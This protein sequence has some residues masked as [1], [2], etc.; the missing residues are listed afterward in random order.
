MHVTM[1]TGKSW[2]DVGVIDERIVAMGALKRLTDGCAEIRRMR[3]HPRMQR[4]AWARR[5]CGHL[6]A[7]PGATVV[8]C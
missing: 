3:V 6:S 5:C 8:P 7:R 1:L 2:M 4:W